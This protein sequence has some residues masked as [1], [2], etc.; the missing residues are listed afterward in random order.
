MPARR[1]SRR[2]PAWGR[3]PRRPRRSAPR[4]P[5]HWRRTSPADR[6]RRSGRRPGKQICLSSRSPLREEPQAA[7]KERGAP[8]GRPDSG[9]RWVVIAGNALP[10]RFQVHRCSVP[11][12]FRGWHFP[13]GRSRAGGPQLR[14]SQVRDSLAAHISRCAGRHRKAGSGTRGWSGTGAAQQRDAGRPLDRPFPG[15]RGLCP[16]R[17][18]RQRAAPTSCSSPRAGSTGC[19]SDRSSRSA[20]PSGRKTSFCWPRPQRSQ[21]PSERR[22]RRWQPLDCLPRRP[23][24]CSSS[25]RHR[26]SISRRTARCAIW[27]STG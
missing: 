1:R 2:S 14:D 21:P 12:L 22:P 16:D 5:R 15:G 24:C 3:R 23:P 6:R 8:S 11:S 13:T 10:L 20:R 18:Q 17:L 27:F 26:W 19:R 25:G 4:R 7:P 9:D